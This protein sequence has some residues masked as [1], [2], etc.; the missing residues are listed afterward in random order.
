LFSEQLM[1]DVD[2]AKARTACGERRS[3]DGKKN[4]CGGRIMDLRE[5][6]PAG[7]GGGGVIALD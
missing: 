2:H 1:H 5:G 4:R 7:V 3:T 6:V